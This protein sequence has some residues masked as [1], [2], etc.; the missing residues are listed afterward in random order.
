MKKF[1]LFAALF[2]FAAA[3]WAQNITP[4]GAIDKTPQRPSAEQLTAAKM[5]DDGWKAVEDYQKNIEKVRAEIRK[6]EEKLNKEREAAARK[7]AKAVKAGADARAKELTGK[8]TA[9]LQNMNAAQQEAFGR[10]L[11]N[12][13]M[14]GMDKQLAAMGGGMAFSGVNS[15]EDLMKLEGAGE[16]EMMKAMAGSD[17]TFGG[18]TQ[19]E[20]KDLQKIE[21]NK[22]LSDKQKEQEIEK[23]M[24]Q[25]P[26]RVKRVE[27]WQKKNEPQLKKMEADN[28]KQQ[29]QTDAILK[30]Q[31]AVKAIEDQI[32]AIQKRW[33]GIDDTNTKE[34]EKAL[35][36]IKKVYAKYD[37]QIR[38]I[39]MSGGEGGVFEGEVYTPEEQ[40]KR[41][42]LDK[43]VYLE[44]YAIWRAYIEAALTRVKGKMADTAK[45]DELAAKKTEMSG[46]D[47]TY[48]ALLSS[49]GDSSGYGVAQEYLN[50]AAQVENLP[51]A[52]RNTTPDSLA[53]AR[54]ADKPAAKTAPAKKAAKPAAKEVKAEDVKEGVKK[55]LGALKSLF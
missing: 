7:D 10:Q 50:L 37:P 34:A 31:Q 44:T 39:P 8:T 20:M 46:L 48:K 40:A 17:G 13:R 18:L 14:A 36:S 16:E 41:D 12:E 28:A 26:D 27:A 47:A 52:Q 21:N 32:N 33:Q 35:A 25:D 11:A 55:G 6:V 29:A 23:Y 22:K 51:A 2:V 49:K 43:T 42:A 4:Q 1:T 15:L 54:A 30:Q 53:A 19:A 9:Q 5:T 45:L 24:K 38:A 3:V